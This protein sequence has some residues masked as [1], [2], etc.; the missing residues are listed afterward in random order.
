M[1][2]LGCSKRLFHY[3]GVKIDLGVKSMD[4]TEGNN[5]KVN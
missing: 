3:L 1:G 4:L 2:G 5:A